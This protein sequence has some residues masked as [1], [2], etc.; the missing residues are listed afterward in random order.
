MVRSSH[1]LSPLISFSQ[2]LLS[3][4]LAGAARVFWQLTIQHRSLWKRP[5]H[6]PP[7]C[8]PKISSLLT[9]LHVASLG[10]ELSGFIGRARGIQTA[11]STAEV[12]VCERGS[13]GA[14]LSAGQRFDRGSSL[15][16]W[17]QG[18]DNTESSVRKASVFCL[19][20]IYSVIGEELKPHLAQLTGSKVWVLLRGQVVRRASQCPGPAA[21]PV[22]AA[23]RLPQRV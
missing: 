8:H 1:L 22:W 2:S 17:L 23:D 14:M 11:P 13:I 9:P 7:P 12:E 15:S 19:V 18:Y 16:L 4:V 6:Q 3:R 20:A 5:A 21:L 10:P